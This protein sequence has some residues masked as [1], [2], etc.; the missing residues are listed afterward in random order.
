MNSHMWDSFIYSFELTFP[1]CVVSCCCWCISEH[2]VYV[3]K[4]SALHTWQV[5][6]SKV[7][8][9]SAEV[10]RYSGGNAGS[11]VGQNTLCVL[12]YMLHSVN[13]PQAWVNKCLTWVMSCLCVCWILVI[14]L[15]KVTVI[16]STK[17]WFKF[18][19]TEKQFVSCCCIYI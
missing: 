16:N 4:L 10:L 7:K 2:C 19:Q 11:A 5:N 6:W 3:F 9:N 14:R 1:W 8:E 13:S 18:K 12:D 15:N 17:L